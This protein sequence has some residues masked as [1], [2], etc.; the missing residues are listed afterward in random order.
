M[1]KPLESRK[2]AENE[3]FENIAR[4][5]SWVKENLE[6]LGL[7]NKDD[8]YKF[9]KEKFEFYSRLYLN[10]NRAS[11][12]TI[13]GLEHLRYISITK[14]A[15]SFYYPLLLAPINISD[16]ELTVNKKLG[17]VSRFIE[18]FIVL[19][20]VN[21]RTLAHSSIRYTK[22]NL[23]KEIRDKSIEELSQ[24]LKLKLEKSDSLEGFEGMIDFRLNQQN[25]RYVHFLLARLTNFIET[26]SQMH[27]RLENYV[28][29]S[30]AK[31]FE[32]EHI[33][34]NRFED[35]KDEFSQKTDF[36]NYRNM[37][38]ALILVP[39]GFNQSYGADQFK[40]KLSHYY[41]QNLLAKSLSS[42]CYEKNPAFLK[43]IHSYNI[44]FK[45]HSQFR[46][47]DIEERQ[48]LYQRICELIWNTNGFIEIA[49][50]NLSDFDKI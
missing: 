17:L 18:T 5:H 33:W 11:K 46:R 44:P 49:E 29:E 12:E 8:F 34:S 38:G 28:V 2:G 39:N 6:K 4:F 9:V 32:I 40:Q 7:Q 14:F 41:G 19:R 42:Q 27:S 16:D 3:D 47:K 36:E 25:K 43:F 35:H 15:T 24:I 26:K 21:N 13:R 45:P 31:R 30:N 22:Y 10:I 1:Q 48:K 20:F 50:S 23:I 37:I